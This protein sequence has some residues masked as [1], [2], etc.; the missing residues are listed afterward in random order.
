MECLSSV[1]RVLQENEKLDGQWS[2]HRFDRS[3]NPVRFPWPAERT[4]AVNSQT[5]AA[6]SLTLGIPKRSVECLQLKIEYKVRCPFN[7]AER[8]AQKLF[9]LVDSPQK[10]L[11]AKIAADLN[12]WFL[13]TGKDVI[14]HG[15]FSTYLRIMEERTRT[16]IAQSGLD[17]DDIKINL[18][19]NPEPKIVIRYD[20]RP[21]DL[22]NNCKGVPLTLS[23]DIELSIN[24]E[25]ARALAH[26]YEGQETKLEASIHDKITEFFLRISLH[27][28]F[29]ERETVQAELRK[30]LESL[31]APRGRRLGR[32]VLAPS[33]TPHK[34][35]PVT[36]AFECKAG[37]GIQVNINAEGSL[38]VEDYGKY[39]DPADWRKQQDLWPRL[40]T[41]LKD[42]AASV[43][44]H[45]PFTEIYSKLQRTHEEIVAPVKREASDHG[46]Q[47]VL[48][49]QFF[50]PYS[51]L[52]QVSSIHRIVKCQVGSAL[53]DCEIRTDLDI[54]L[55]DSMPLGKYKLALE[56][57]RNSFEMEID[58]CTKSALSGCS[59]GE[60]FAFESA[61]RSRIT[62]EIETGLRIRFGLEVRKIQLER[63]DDA[64]AKN[65]LRIVQEAPL[66]R[67]S[68]P[69]KPDVTFT[70]QFRVLD[71]VASVNPSFIPFPS[72]IENVTT[73]VVGYVRQ[74]LSDL[75]AGLL[76]GQNY[77]Q[78]LR[79]AVNQRLYS[80]MLEKHALKIDLMYMVPDQPN[81]FSPLNDDL[82]ELM[83][84]LRTLQSD[85]YGQEADRD[86]L[87]RQMSLIAM[88]MHAQGEAVPWEN[89]RTMKVECPDAPKLQSPE[90]MIK[91]LIGAE[92]HKD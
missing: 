24:D 15:L 4:L 26:W 9:S 62:K 41:M 39:M 16:V 66:F 19:S 7:G 84:K 30:T 32:L 27:R 61:V 79:G 22:A 18:T 55:V 17:V 50:W 87:R 36:E 56:E 58:R 82:T 29:N 1:V 91:G 40:L 21:V 45:M 31:L 81:I 20:Q 78:V 57:L 63:H 49:L 51:A 71:Y 54:I 92:T 64:A 83:N 28:Y 14:L 5:R 48:R 37:D 72:S 12:A 85:P 76:Y 90:E 34:L 8:A 46:A 75:P 43:L 88:E 47:L 73:L 35:V 60:Y 69:S 6:C 74:I 65:L 77:K 42:R 70:G 80:I 11:E 23:A 44:A 67:V 38:H 13:A 3:G 89:L 33:E 53:A 52:L 59:L 10:I 86:E 68:H 25:Y 2:K